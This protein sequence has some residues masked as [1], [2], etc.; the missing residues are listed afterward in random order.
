MAQITVLYDNY[1]FDERLE[2]AWGISC[3][4]TGLDRTIL[5]DTG[6]KAEVLQN[7]FEKMNV[8]P[9]SID[10]VVISH[11]HWDHING[12]EWLVKENSNLD[13]YL[14]ASATDE[15]IDELKP[16]CKSVQRLAESKIL[17]KGVYTTGTFE[18]DIPEQ[19]LCVQTEKG[20]VVI[21][22]CS[23]PGIVRILKSVKERSGSNI[24]MVIG[25]FH[26]KAHQPDQIEQIVAEIKS[27]GVK[28]IGP[29]HCTGV[30]AIDASRQCWQENFVELGVGNK[31]VLD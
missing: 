30:E 8:S 15:Y 31:I 26:L 27:L 29:T 23:H 1:K 9:D 11:M 10:C 25:G 22:G 4:I 3:L 16:N 14:P 20:L 28:K 2:D 18:H 7:N 6:G 17:C 13:I 24:E 19:S 5:F 12:L 21:T